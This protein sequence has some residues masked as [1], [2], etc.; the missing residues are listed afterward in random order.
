HI[1][2]TFNATG[3]RAPLTIGE[4][5]AGCRAASSGSND[6]K[7]TWVDTAFL[8]E[9][10]VRGWSDMP[11]WQAPRDDNAGWGRV[12]IERAVAQGLTFRP[13]AVTARDTI[14]WFK[15]LPAERQGKML[16]GLTPE[17]EKELL[18]KWHQLHG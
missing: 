15:T 5:L 11:T 18:A 2:G 14:D 17:R 8:A 10:K 16:A 9:Q 13:L 7:L 12:S 6:V 3:P 1:I 4:M